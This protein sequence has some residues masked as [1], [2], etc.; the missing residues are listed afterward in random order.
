M[1]LQVDAVAPCNAVYVNG[2]YYQYF[3]IR[4]DRLSVDPEVGRCWAEH[5]SLPRLGC[6]D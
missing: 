5:G 4:I 2:Y 6:D 1:T 3:D